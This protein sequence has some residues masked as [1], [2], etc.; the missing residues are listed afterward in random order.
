MTLEPW[1]TFCCPGPEGA[2]VVDEVVESQG[3]DE[4]GAV[5]GSVHLERHV[6]LVQPHRLAL[7]RQGRLEQLPRHLGAKMESVNVKLQ[8]ASCNQKGPRFNTC[9]GQYRCVLDMLSH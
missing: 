6:A 8:K 3:D 2:V 7:L 1:P 4:E 9:N 5:A